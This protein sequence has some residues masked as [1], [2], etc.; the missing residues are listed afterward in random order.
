MGEKSERRNTQALIITILGSDIINYFKILTNF[1]KW[2]S[3]II[4]RK[5]KYIV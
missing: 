3:I 4:N 1:L 5:H 2:A